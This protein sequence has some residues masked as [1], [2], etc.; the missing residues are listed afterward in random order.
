MPFFA[1][2]RLNRKLNELKQRPAVAEFLSRIP[3]GPKARARAML[4]RLSA[5]GI[6]QRIHS[7]ANQTNN[8][9]ARFLYEQAQ[10]SPRFAEPGRLLRHGYKIYS[11]HD[12]DGIIE[13]IFRR[14]GATNESFIEF[15]VGEGAENCTLYLL[16][17]G[18]RGAWIDASA[19]CYEE[20]KRQLDYLIQEDRLRIKH[21]FVSME[22]IE[23]L[24]AEL[25]VAEEPD[26]LSVDIDSNDYWIWKAIRLYRP[27]VV[28]IEYNAALGPSPAVTIPY[29]GRRV[30]N[31]S[32]YYGASL[33]ALELLGRE[34]GYSLVGCNYTGVSAFFVRNDLVKP[35]R[36]LEPFTAENHWEPARYFCRMPNGHA[37]AT[38]PMVQVDAPAPTPKQSL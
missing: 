1:I 17:K 20:S 37:P 29:N 9:L 16:L 7:Q 38:G 15:G 33:K 5:P 27:R 28:V 2:S 34:K 18:W 35:G 26:L 36:F 3:A 24:F 23:T 12:E 14:V 8:L 21:A 31:L 10:Q 11:Q 30:W 13:E 25:G 32:N 22:N 4:D 6:H 19:I